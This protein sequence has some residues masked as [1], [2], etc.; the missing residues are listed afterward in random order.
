MT[1]ILTRKTNICLS[2][3]NYTRSNHYYVTA[4]TENKH[5]WFGEINKI[6]DNGHKFKWQR[7]FYDH[8]IRNE[9]SLRKIREYITNNPVAWAED[10]ENIKC[11]TIKS[12]RPEPRP[13]LRAGGSRQ[14]QKT[15]GR[16]RSCRMMLVFF[17]FL[18][19]I[20]SVLI[21]GEDLICIFCH[22]HD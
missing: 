2:G 7:S 1:K 13:D 3:Y 5:E 17:S 14:K 6:T 20:L 16:R 22:S 11:I 9:K 18:Y 10:E 19:H 15:A 21:R 8:I 12:S 4:C